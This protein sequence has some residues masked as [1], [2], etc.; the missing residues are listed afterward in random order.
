MW[1]SCRTQPIFLARAR[2]KSIGPHI[3]HSFETRCR[4]SFGTSDL[5]AGACCGWG[6]DVFD[7]GVDAV[8]GGGSDGGGESGFVIRAEVEE[9]VDGGLLAG[10]ASG[11]AG[12]L[13]CGEEGGAGALQ[14]I[15]GHAV[16]GEPGE[17][18]VQCGAGLSG[19]LGEVPR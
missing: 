19:L 7:E 5:D 13:A 1:V 6:E 18:V 12:E 8:L 17:G 9:L 16:M 11:L 3:Y 4:R 10:G 15:Q 14:G 2:E